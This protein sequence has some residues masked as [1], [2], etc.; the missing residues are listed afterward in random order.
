MS[1]IF[2]AA[3][4][5]RKRLSIQHGRTSLRQDGFKLVKVYKKGK[6]VMT[7]VPIPQPFRKQDK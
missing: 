4:R 7:K 6:P 3:E 1:S 5:Y 2:R